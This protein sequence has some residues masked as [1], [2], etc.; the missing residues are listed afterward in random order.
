[1][2]PVVRWLYFFRSGPFSDACG[3]T[4]WLSKRMF[5]V[6]GLAQDTHWLAG[7]EGND[8]MCKVKLAAAA[9]GIDIVTSAVHG[10]F[11][12]LGVNW[13]PLRVQKK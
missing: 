2:V 4:L 10:A 13:Q 11:Y 1:M 8:D 6:T 3:L 12:S 7:A 9:V 5:G